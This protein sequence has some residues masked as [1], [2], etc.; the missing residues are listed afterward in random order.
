M[1]KNE[2]KYQNTK[3]S[4]PLT[5]LA[6]GIYILLLIG[7]VYGIV[8]VYNMPVS[9]DGFF[10]YP[11]MKGTALYMLGLLL[12]IAIFIILGAIVGSMK[13]KSKINK[14]NKN[15]EKTNPYIYYRELPNK[16]G[17]GVATLL[18]DSKI[19]NKKDII[20]VILDLCAQ[21]Y[22]SLT[23]IQNKYCIKVLKGTDETLLKNEKYI[24]SMILSKNLNNMDY[25]QWYQYCLQDGEDL[26]L[27][28]HS[29]KKNQTRNEEFDPQIYLKKSFKILRNISLS[30]GLAVYLI[31]VICGIPLG[32]VC[33]IVA[34][35]GTF[36]VLLIPFYII[37]YVIG[38][39]KGVSNLTKSAVNSNY[40]ITLNNHLTRTEKGKIEL[41]KL[42]SFQK[43]LS[44]FGNFVNK[45][46]EEVVLW[47]R[48][49]SYAQ[50]FGLTKEIMSS[51]YNQLVNNSSFQIDNIDNINMSNIEV[52]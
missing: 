4:I 13:G 7:L 15:I 39:V 2:T 9:E 38:V 52:E 6:I 18:F 35:I 27:Y 24:L 31:F 45:N 34:I 30:V 37:S 43:F 40:N 25:E 26:E 46:P 51:G 8:T 14:E 1:N 5:L 29:D 32:F 10:Q 49:L 21:K 42:I 44:D 50:V 22:L 23:K 16:Y 17:I 48:Y 11:F 3:T 19:E 47:D 28:Y 36:I 33:A 20:A 12:C 41:Q